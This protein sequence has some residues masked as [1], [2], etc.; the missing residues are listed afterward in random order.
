MDKLRCV[1]IVLLT[2]VPLLAVAVD[3]RRLS[4]SETAVTVDGVIDAGEYSI[5]YETRGLRLFLSRDASQLFAAVTANTRGWVAI[6]FG[7]TMMNGAH[8]LLSYVT[9][10]T[11]HVVEQKGVEFHG[12][13][14][15]EETVVTGYAV[16]E[17]G[18]GTVLETSVALDALAT[19]IEENGSKLG[20]IIAYATRDSLRVK[21]RARGSLNVI[22][23]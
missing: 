2:G 22:L 21:H 3:E 7:S 15:T 4:E 16:V 18:S 17:S 9:D 14:D 6:G 20:V 8:I 1:L 13:E 5:E 12:H 19:M 23:E 11:A 10:G